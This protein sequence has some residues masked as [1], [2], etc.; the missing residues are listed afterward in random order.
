[1]L[2]EWTQFVANVATA[3]GILGFAFVYF[4]HQQSQRQFM[5]TVMLSCIERFQRLFPIIRNDSEDLD[6]LRKYIDLTNEEFF[7]FQRNYVPREVVVEWLDSIVEMLPI[8]Q[9][10]EEFPVNM[11]SPLVR[12]IHEHKV[13]SGYPRLMV[14]FTIQKEVDFNSKAA[15]IRAVCVNLGVKVT[16]VHFK[17]AHVA[18]D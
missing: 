12:L 7:Y 2:F 5:F 1:M 10:G 18:L 15:L 4:T 16:N 13:L 9:H 3:L 14:A 17:R 6:R 8:Y 11:G